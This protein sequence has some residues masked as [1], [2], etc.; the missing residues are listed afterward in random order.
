MGWIGRFLFLE[1]RHLAAFRAGYART[2]I[3]ASKLFKRVV[4]TVYF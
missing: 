2:K 4:M 1:R 3:L